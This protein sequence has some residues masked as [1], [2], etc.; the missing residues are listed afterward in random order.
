MCV[1]K[2]CVVKVSVGKV[3]VGIC[4]EGVCSEHVCSESTVLVKGLDTN[5][6]FKGFSFFISIL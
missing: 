1:V 2:W 4:S 5:Y 6:S 3:S